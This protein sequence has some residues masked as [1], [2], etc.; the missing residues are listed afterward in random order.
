MTIDA[1]TRSTTRS[2]M[3]FPVVCDPS[4]PEATLAR[5][6]SSVTL[7]EQTVAIS[8]F[9]AS[10]PGYGYDMAKGNRV[11]PFI[12]AAVCRASCLEGL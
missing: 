10:D 8:L 2:G 7:P 3:A 12:I 9:A 5:S 11:S 6:I 4:P 1:P